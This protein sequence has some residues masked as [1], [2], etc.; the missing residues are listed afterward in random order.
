V[1]NL[2]LVDNLGGTSYIPFKI[3]SRLRK[4]DELWN[5]RY[6]EFTTKQDV[7]AVNYHQRSTIESAFSSIKRKFGERLFT[8]NDVAQ[9][10]EILTKIL[11]SER[12]T[13]AF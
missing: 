2:H 7:F 8:K 5:E 3:D 4:G 11:V 6:E 1:K 12:E 9:E 13:P 10:N